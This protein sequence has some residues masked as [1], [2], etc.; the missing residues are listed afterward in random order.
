MWEI[1]KVGEEQVSCS[2]LLLLTLQSDEDKEDGPPELLFIHGGHT[3]EVTDFA[4]NKHEPWRCASVSDDNILHI[5]QM[6]QPIYADCTYEDELL[7]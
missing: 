4:W 6:A 7:A 2:F 5:W 3:G 1:R